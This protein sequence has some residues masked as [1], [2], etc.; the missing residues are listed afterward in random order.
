MSHS[1]SGLRGVTLNDLFVVT[2][3]RA[4]DM[5]SL[6]E[7]VHE[8]ATNS[9]RQ[10]LSSGQ[11]LF[12]SLFTFVAHASLFV[13]TYTLGSFLLPLALQ[14]IESVTGL[15]SQYGSEPAKLTIA[16]I[17]WT[18]AHLLFGEDFYSALKKQFPMAPKKQVDAGKG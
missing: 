17:I 12:N 4:T 13:G 8:K 1:S 10:G 16:G 9:S 11:L 14:H 7:P 6:A 3:K 18:I 5:R 2:A 15:V